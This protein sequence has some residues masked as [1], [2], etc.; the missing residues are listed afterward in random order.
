MKGKA[1]IGG[2]LESILLGGGTIVLFLLLW[3]LIVTVTGVDFTTPTEIFSYIFNHMTATIGEHT[4]IGHVG[5]SLSRV[6]V[7]YILAA[8]SGII[9]GLAMA[10]WEVAKAIIS[11]IFN[12][13]RPIPPIGWA[14]LAILWFGVDEAAKYFIIFIGGFVPF[15]MNTFVGATRVDRKLVDAALMLGTSPGQLFR[16][17]T[18]PAIVPQIFAGAQVA[19]TSTWM[20]V[21]GAE[22][23]RSTEGAG[24]II[25]KGMEMADIAQIISGMFVIGLT[26]FLVATIMRILEKRL[27]RWNVRGS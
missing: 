25:L 12:I 8:I 18:F 17:I 20:T 23:L 13:L 11:P 9:I 10:Q 21:L 1:L 7:G 2:R 19:L 4:I 26:G 24:W 22:M 27:I 14:P 6:L 3:Q 5:W 16:K 15:T